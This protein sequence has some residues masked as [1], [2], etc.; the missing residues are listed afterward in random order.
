MGKEIDGVRNGLQKI[1]NLHGNMYNLKHVKDE[2]RPFQK[3]IHS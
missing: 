1:V 2:H 3:P